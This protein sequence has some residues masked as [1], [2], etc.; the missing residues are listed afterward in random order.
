M[1]QAK[2]VVSAVR[3]ADTPG[4]KGAASRL[5]NQYVLQQQQKGMDPMRVRAAIKAVVNRG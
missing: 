2:T 5:L 3:N 1:I 4:K